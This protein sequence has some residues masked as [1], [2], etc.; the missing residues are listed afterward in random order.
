MIYLAF[1]ISSW[2]NE[3]W[4]LELMKM[5]EW[6]ENENLLICHILNV[7]LVHS[8][9]STFIHMISADFFSLSCFT[10][11]QRDCEDLRP[12]GLPITA[13]N[14]EL[15]TELFIPMMYKHV[16]L[17]NSLGENLSWT[18]IIL[19]DPTRRIAYF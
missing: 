10:P 16:E 11:G 4:F 2:D 13:N 17:S 9:L 8:F 3:V 19:T 12:N 18:C 14:F 6:N 15:L 7:T 5:N 1:V